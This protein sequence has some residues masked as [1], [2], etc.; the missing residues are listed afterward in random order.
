MDCPDGCALE[1]GVEDGRI[2]SVGPAVGEGT[3]FICGKVANFAKRVYHQDRILHPLRR[4]GAK[5]SG[6]FEVITWQQALDDIAE[7][8]LAAREDFG[9]ESILPYHYGGSNGALT[10]GLLDDLF[11]ARLGASRLAKTICAVPATEVAVGMY[12][13]MPGVAFE[14]YEKAK[15]IVVWGAN[16]KG[17]NIHLVPHLRN[18]R[19]KGAFIASIDPRNNFGTGEIDLH[20]GV[21]PG[22]DLPIALAMINRWRQ[23]GVVDQRFLRDHTQGSE[24]LFERAAEWTLERAAATAGVRSRDVAYIADKL[25]E[26]SP[27]VVRC[28][29]G[30]ERNRNGAQA[31]AAV[32][33]IPAVLGKFGVPGG[34]YTLS[35]NGGS[36]FDRDA[37]IGP[38]DWTTRELN[39]TQLGR[40]ID[41]RHEEAPA[42]PVKVLFV[43]NA[44]PVASTPHQAA[45]ERGLARG[46]PVHRGARPGD[47]RHRTLGRYRPAG[48]D[49]PRGH[50]SA[51]QLRR[52]R[53]RGHPPGD[54]AGR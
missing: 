25:A 54:R 11:F 3:D 30:L 14:D 17:S 45:I 1:V 40:Q 47:D 51:G 42:P 18:A 34:G 9:G 49:L 22:Q 52:L 19:A 24:T 21:L 39:M 46:R 36:R 48:G 13:K 16:P 15:C 4:K 12:G 26:S 20:L 28:G 31:I 38:V 33:A 23:Q 43:Y 44:N 41:P 29:W 32:L 5:G 10:D 53:C 50:R 27:A 8:M 6:Q 35:N 37:V 7:R 2:V